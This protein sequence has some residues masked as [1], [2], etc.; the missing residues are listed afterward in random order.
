MRR[1]T[2][3]YSPTFSSY[4]LA[5]Q[6]HTIQNLGSSSARVVLLGSRSPL[7]TPNFH[8]D[9][10]PIIFSE[11]A[12]F[13]LSLA[14]VTKGQEPFPGCPQLQAYKLVRAAHLA[15]M[16]HMQ[17]ANRSVFLSATSAF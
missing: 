11:I 4:I 1:N 5:P 16:G 13:A 2:R 9:H 12:E 8:T 10:D 6:A 3:R 15:E 14:P 17:T 7:T